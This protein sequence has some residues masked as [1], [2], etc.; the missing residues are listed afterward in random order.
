MTRRLPFARREVR[1]D[2]YARWRD[3][4]R[5]VESYVYVHRLLAVA[6]YGFDALEGMHVH[7]R[8]HI[9]WDN[10]PENIELREPAEHG[11]YHLHGEELEGS[12]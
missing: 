3:C 5:G 10:R 12:A 1:E 9:R 11:C 6:E 7:H 4:C 8:N 2:G